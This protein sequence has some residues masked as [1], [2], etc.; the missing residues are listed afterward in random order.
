[1]NN[2]KYLF[3]SVRFGVLFVIFT[4]SIL[5]QT[6]PAPKDVLGFTPGDDYKLSSWSRIVDYFQKLDVASDRVIFKEIGKTTEGKP[7]TYATSSGA[8][9]LKKLDYYKKDQRSTCRSETY[10]TAMIKRREK[11][12]NKAKHLF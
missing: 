11:S 5:A 2:R 8:D 4:F 7:F 12:S 9:N 6:V 1:M 10:S 3:A